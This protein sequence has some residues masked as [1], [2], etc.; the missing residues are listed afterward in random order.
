MI[1]SIYTKSPD[2]EEN[3]NINS[4]AKALSYFFGSKKKKLFL[5]EC[6]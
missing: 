2:F 6:S 4:L 3:R 5:A 1:V